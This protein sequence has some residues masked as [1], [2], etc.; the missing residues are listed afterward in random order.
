MRAPCAPKPHLLQQASP[1]V[2]RG[3]DGLRRA[4]LLLGAPETHLSQLCLEYYKH[5]EIENRDLRI[6][7]VPTSTIRRIHVS[8]TDILKRMDKQIEQVVVYRTLF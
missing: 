7:N 8:K 3:A 1:G 5:Y 2:R 4:A 6:Y